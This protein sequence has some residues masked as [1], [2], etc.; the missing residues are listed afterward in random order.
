M[1]SK[2][3]LREFPANAAAGK[4]LLWIGLYRD[5]KNYQRWLWVDG[6]TAYFTPRDTEEIRDLL[7]SENC[8]ELDLPSKKLNDM[9]CHFRLPYICVIN[10]KY[11]IPYGHI[12]MQTI[13]RL[14]LVL[15]Q[16]KK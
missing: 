8:G 7:P 6:S 14:K 9:A 2:A 1:N 3:K 16:Q 4:V 5:P 12:Y 15:R 11:N 10:G 13:D